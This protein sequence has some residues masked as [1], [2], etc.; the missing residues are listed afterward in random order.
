MRT[1]L[2]ALTKKVEED[3]P[4]T[5]FRVRLVRVIGHWKSFAVFV[6]ISLSVVP[7]VSRS[8][9]NLLAGSWS[10]GGVVVYASGDRERARCHAHY[11]PQGDARVILVATCATPS[12][13][14]TQTARLRKTGASS[15]TGTFF[16]SQFSL[17]GTIHVI[18]NGSSQIIRLM[19]SSG[20]AS[21]T[22]TH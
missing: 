21:L 16:N 20:S 12:G 9:T 2:N 15:Y 18:V 4:V 1:S 22:L 8:E 19:S 17:S 6:F 14:V 5:A 10:G 3:A 11:S 13:S 7:Q